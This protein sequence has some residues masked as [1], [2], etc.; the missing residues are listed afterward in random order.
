M[1][2]FSGCVDQTAEPAV[3]SVEPD[4]QYRDDEKNFTL[5]QPDAL[6]REA[7][8]PGERN[9]TSPPLWRLGE[10]WTYRAEAFLN[11]QVE[12]I[13]RIVAGSEH[14]NFLVGFPIDQ[15]SNFALVLHNPAYGDVHRE[16]INYEMH[17][18]PFEHVQ[19]PLTLGKTWQTTFESPTVIWDAVITEVDNASLTARIDFTNAA[20][21]NPAGYAIYDAELGEATTLYFN[22]YGRFDI[23]D[24]G[25]DYDGDV[26]VP[27]DHDLTF[28]HGCI[29]GAQPIQPDGSTGAGCPD[30]VIEMPPGYD[31]VSFGLLAQDVAAQQGSGPSQGNERFLGYYTIDVEA[32]D[33]TQ[34]SMSVT[35]ET[36]GWFVGDFY[37]H[38]EPAGQWTYSAV[39]AGPGAILIEGIGYHSIDISLPSGCVIASAN[40]DHHVTL[41]KDT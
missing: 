1:A 10:W 3:V 20:N 24:H 7:P 41:C 33:G 2:T 29:A 11:G 14:N 9:L 6:P 37:E 25:Y 16:N 35:P 26:R 5:L 31:R 4:E 8:L 34:Y 18:S 38:E 39:A 32:P 27:H 30:G 12:D 13:S 21:G 40:A 36:S 19:F 17:D 28:F 22:G 23:T 15:F